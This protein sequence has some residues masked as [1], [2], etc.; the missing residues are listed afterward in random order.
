MTGWNTPPK[1]SYTMLPLPLLN[2]VVIDWRKPSIVVPSTVVAIAR[3]PARNDDGRCCQSVIWSCTFMVEHPVFQSC[4]QVFAEVD[5]R[6][7]DGILNVFRPLVG[8]W[9]VSH[10]LTFMNERM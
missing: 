10:C 8:R 2:F 4:K 1:N 5:S 9:F 3:L 6:P 7:A